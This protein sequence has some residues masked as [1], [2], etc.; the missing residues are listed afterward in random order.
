VSSFP[1]SLL[2]ICIGFPVVLKHTWTLEV[3]SARL[4]AG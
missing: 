4:L 2:I 1:T 3:R